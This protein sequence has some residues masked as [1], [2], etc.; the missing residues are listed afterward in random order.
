MPKPVGAVD[1]SLTGGNRL[2]DTLVAMGVV[3]EDQAGF[4]R[5]MLGLYAVPS[6]EDALTSKIEFKEDGGIYANGQRVF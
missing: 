1:L 6:G 4:A 3:P 2:I 5:M